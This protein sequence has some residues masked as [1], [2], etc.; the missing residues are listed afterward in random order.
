MEAPGELLERI[1]S[2]STECGV[3]LELTRFWANEFRPGWYCRF[4][5]AVHESLAL[6][7]HIAGSLA[8]DLAGERQDEVELFLFANGDR[9]GR[10]EKPYEYLHRRGEGPFQWADLDDGFQVQKTLRS[11]AMIDD[12]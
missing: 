12:K 3:A 10:L 11:I 6:T 1:R 5:G 2:L 7:I 8:V 4:R 9:L